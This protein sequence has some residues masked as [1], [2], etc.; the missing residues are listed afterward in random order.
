MGPRVPPL[1]GE[2]SVTV[3]VG[4]GKQRGVSGSGAKVS[5]IVVT[6]SEVGAMIKKQAKA[7]FDELVTIA[8]QVVAP[9]LVNDN[10]HDQLRPRII[11]G[12]EGHRTQN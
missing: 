11:G 12:A 9:E 4:S 3:A 8:L 5:I 7:I 2:N 1:V 10:H 6:V